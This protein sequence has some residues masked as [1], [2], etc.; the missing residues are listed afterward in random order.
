MHFVVIMDNA[1]AYV[2]WNHSMKRLPTVP[3]TK[4]MV[5]SILIS[6]LLWYIQGERKCKHD[7]AQQILHDIL[8]RN[9]N[10]ND[11]EPDIKMEHVPK[12]FWLPTMFHV[13]HR[14]RGYF[15]DSF[16][17]EIAMYMIT[18]IDACIANAQLFR[19][20]WVDGD[21]GEILVEWSSLF[22]PLPTPSSVNSGFQAIQYSSRGL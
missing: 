14:V 3:P 9:R 7:E 19:R 6:S 21:S 18:Q 10:F 2:V 8:V 11:T 12:D 22:Q 20:E 13:L 17:M 4:V 1:D 5:V 15:I 16:V